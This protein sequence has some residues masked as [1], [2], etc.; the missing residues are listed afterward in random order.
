M[1]DERKKSEPAWIRWTA[2]VLPLYPLSMG[3]V[4]WIARHF[5]GGEYAVY[6]YLPLLLLGE[7]FTPLGDMLRWYGRLGL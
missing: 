3:P 2:L 6:A 1:S 5:E 7:L 4:L